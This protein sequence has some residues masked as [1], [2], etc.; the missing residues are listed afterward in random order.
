MD[1]PFFSERVGLPDKLG[2]GGLVGAGGVGGGPLLVVRRNS[3]SYWWHRWHIIFTGAGGG[4]AGD[5]SSAEGSSAGGRWHIFRRLGASTGE[6]GAGKV[7]LLF[8]QCRRGMVVEVN[9]RSGWIFI[10]GSW[11]RGVISSLT[12][13]G[14]S[15]AGVRSDISSVSPKEGAG[16]ISVAGDGI[17]LG[18][19]G[20]AGV[21][22][23]SSSPNEGI[24]GN[25]N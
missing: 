24:G 10:K 17:H 13:S 21:S 11:G 3:I 25:S 23:E 14:V 20:G 5:S 22:T 7:D 16:G 4:G 8:L 6:G 2:F 1:L 12:S 9:R 15:G 19:E 18:D